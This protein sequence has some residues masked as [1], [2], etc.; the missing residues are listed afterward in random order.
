L[1]E[2]GVVKLLPLI[3]RSLKVEP[4]DEP[5]ATSQWDNVESMADDAEEIKKIAKDVYR[6]LGS[7]FSEGVY[8]RAMQVGLRR[9][10]MSST[11]YRFQE[12][13]P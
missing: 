6:V 10:K 1:A 4:K 3:R 2:G 11:V 9:A 5:K 8:D 12:N 13:T 7:G